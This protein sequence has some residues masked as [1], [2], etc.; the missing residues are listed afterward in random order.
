MLTIK[1][2]VL[3]TLKDFL[4]IQRGDLTAV[5]RFEDPL[6]DRSHFIRTDLRIDRSNRLFYV[7]RRHDV[8][9]FDAF[10]N[11]LNVFLLIVLQLPF[12]DANE[13]AVIVFVILMRTHGENR[14]ENKQS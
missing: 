8:Q 1:D 13:F 12:E 11:V 5:L 3:Q 6:N 7:F 4:N 14:K 2:A 9:I 10:L